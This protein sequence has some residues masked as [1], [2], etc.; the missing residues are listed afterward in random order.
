M[1]YEK[2]LETLESAPEEKQSEYM[3]AMYGALVKMSQFNR[4][5]IS[6]AGYDEPFEVMR[7][8]DEEHYEAAR[9]IFTYNSMISQLESSYGLKDFTS[10]LKRNID[11]IDAQLDQQRQELANQALDHVEKTNELNFA[12]AFEETN[13]Q[14]NEDYM[15][16]A[17]ERIDQIDNNYKAITESVIGPSIRDL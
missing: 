4:E 8:R 15:E 5:Q 11:I 1:N 17:R 6:E 13:N 12:D 7:E 10:H 2:V 3:E 14:L 16:R 9:E